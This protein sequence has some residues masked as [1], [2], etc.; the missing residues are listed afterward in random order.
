MTVTCASC[1]ADFEAKNST[2]KYCSA[3][4]RSRGSRLGRI[5]PDRPP[6]SSGLRDAVVRELIE[7]GRLDTPLGNL[8]LI[9]ADT[10]SSPRTTGSA[11]AS[12]SREL[13]VVMVKAL[14][15]V[16][17]EDHLDE[18]RRKR[19]QKHGNLTGL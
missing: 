4:C 8:A 2:A 14:E 19:E 9:L 1:T 16:R 6:E 7:A 12:L 17:G 3:T 18:L 10:I 5:S 15:G 11:V 13:S